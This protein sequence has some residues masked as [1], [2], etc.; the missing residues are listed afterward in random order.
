MTKKRSVLFHISISKWFKLRLNHSLNY[1]FYLTCYSLLFQ[2]NSFN[3]WTL[4]CVRYVICKLVH[5]MLN[6]STIRN[7]FKC[8]RDFFGLMVNFILS[9]CDNLIDDTVLKKML[10]RMSVKL[11]YVHMMVNNS[12]LKLIKDEQGPSKIII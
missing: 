8:F 3:L 7:L 12:I 4:M 2:F 11:Q 6:S 5:N 9:K 10:V 1:S